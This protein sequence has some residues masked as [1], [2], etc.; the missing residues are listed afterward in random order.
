MGRSILVAVLTAGVG[1]LAT[2]AGASAQQ[3]PQIYT[4]PVVAP[5]PDAASP[6]GARYI[7]GVG[8]RYIAPGG[9]SVYGWVY[10]YRA[11]VYGY[12]RAYRRYYRHARYR[13]YRDACGSYRERC[14]GAR[15]WH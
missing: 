2:L 8:F 9:P 7:P 10:G 6:N 15:R 12:D 14:G 3:N 11:P 13:Y 4:P 1:L 5:E